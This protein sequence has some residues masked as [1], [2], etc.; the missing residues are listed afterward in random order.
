L[1][2][3]D[4]E[5]QLKSFFFF[6]CGDYG[7]YDRNI[8]P[9]SNVFVNLVKKVGDYAFCGVHPSYESNKNPWRLAMEKKRLSKILSREIRFSRQHFL[10]FRLP[11]TYQ[12]LLQNNIDH[13][14]SMG[15]SSQ[16]GFRASVATPYY[17]FDLQREEA[18]S[19]KVFPLAVMDSTLI[20]YLELEPVE[21]LQRVLKIVD[22][23]KK[24][25]GTFISLWHND[26]FAAS[27]NGN[28]WKEC[29]LKIVD[30][31]KP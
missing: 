21:A 1:L 5:Q 10:K 22:E 13:D 2:E 29:Y 14:F 19:L 27:E 16:V 24:V 11:R 4:K 3:I 6:L 31:A 25:N 30:H 9:Y 28:R 8:S 7:P 15:Y 12:T 18:T 23:V 17:Y 26:T 20:R